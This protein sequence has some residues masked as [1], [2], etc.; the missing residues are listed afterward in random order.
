MIAGVQTSFYC[1]LFL[2]C[3]VGRHPPPIAFRL[4]LIA[5]VLEIAGRCYTF[6]C[7][8]CRFQSSLHNRLLLARDRYRLFGISSV[9]WIAVCAS[10]YSDV[11]AIG[12]HPFSFASCG[13]GSFP[14]L[15]SPSALHSTLLLWLL[16]DSLSQC[17]LWLWTALRSSTSPCGY[18]F[19]SHSFSVAI[20]LP[21][22]AICSQDHYLFSTLLC[23]CSVEGSL[24]QSLLVVRVCWS[25]LHFTLLLFY[26]QAAFHNSFPFA[27]KRY[28]S[29]VFN[30]LYAPLHP[31]VV[32]LPGSFSQS[33]PVDRYHGL[34]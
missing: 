18:L 16:P 26:C 11:V 7:C 32:L 3:S 13:S 20:P 10:L 24:Y 5:S 14:C 19:A 27:R 25:V 8:C 22:I 6:L 9:S 29:L 17:C 21:G 4:L 28:L 2:L 12:S 33:L 23:C 1:R 31:A 15:G 30:G 34:Y